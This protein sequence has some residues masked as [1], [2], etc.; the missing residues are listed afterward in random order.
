[1]LISFA[2]V[3]LLPLTVL[4][5]EYAKNFWISNWYLPLVFLTLVAAF[6]IFFLSNWS[7]LKYVEGED[8]NSLKPVLEDR[9]FNRK[10][11][12]YTNI[13]LLVNSYYLT[14]NIESLFTLEEFVEKNK[15]SVYNKTELMFVS[16]RLL[17]NN[18]DETEKYLADKLSGGNDVNI[19]IRFNYCFILVLQKKFDEALLCINPLI[20]LS[21]DRIITLC[22]IYLLYLASGIE[23]TAKTETLRSGFVSENSRDKINKIISKGKGNLHVLFFTRIIDQA[24]EWAYEVK[25]TVN[26]KTD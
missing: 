12:S 8:W 3:F 17:K 10:K 2:A 16:G 22:S 14:N 5:Y 1:M 13:K 7:V 26:L 24:V 19:W 18:T 21:R 20:D 6:N 11:I 9:I 23:G 25:K 4:G 15:P